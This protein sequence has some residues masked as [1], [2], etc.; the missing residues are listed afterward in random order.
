MPCMP[1]STNVNNLACSLVDELQTAWRTHRM[2]AG[3]TAVVSVR[4]LTHLRESAAAL[5]RVVGA[6]S[7]LAPVCDA[8][9]AVAHA[10]VL[11]G[12]A[13]AEVLVALR[14]LIRER[15]GLTAF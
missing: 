2:D 8:I 6:T 1:N 7:P 13:G 9:G 3:L 10:D 12:T 15:A 5:Q 4:V 11:A 14:N